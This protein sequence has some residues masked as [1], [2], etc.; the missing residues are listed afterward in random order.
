[1]GDEK[2]SRWALMRG[3]LVYNDALLNDDTDS[4]FERRIALAVQQAW[5][6]GFR[7]GAETLEEQL[8]A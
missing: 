5:Q 1:M 7:R 8:G 4:E 6:E 2:L 3:A